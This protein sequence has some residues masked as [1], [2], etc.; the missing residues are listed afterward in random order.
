IAKCV[1]VIIYKISIHINSARSL[2]NCDSVVIAVRV[3]L[4]LAII[5]SSSYSVILQ[6]ITIF[7]Q[8][9]TLNTKLSNF[10]LNWRGV[11]LPQ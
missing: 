5:Q 4:V 9:K 7:L 1:S 10:L 6:Q 3:V 11:L 2:F 8:T